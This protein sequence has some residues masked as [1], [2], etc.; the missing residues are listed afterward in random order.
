M[1]DTM[2]PVVNIIGERVALGSLRRDDVPLFYRW[3]N[4]FFVRRTFD[5]PEVWTLERATEEYERHAVAQHEIFFTLFERP[6]PHDVPMRPIGLTYLTDIDFRNR[7]AEFGIL[8]G[9]ADARGKGYGTEATCLTLDYAFTAL[10]LHNIVL[11]V[12][13]YNLAG[14]R[15]YEKAG[16]RTF[17]RRQ[18]AKVMGGAHW[19]MIFMECLA[20]DFTSPSLAS[21]FMSDE[22][23]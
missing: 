10:G 21:V 20:S 12:Y 7:T 23:N 19:D 15:A 11:H 22:S 3:G 13:A 14:I 4:D 2:A 9:E 5:F 17:A 1:E 16:F 6:E 18:D 8:I